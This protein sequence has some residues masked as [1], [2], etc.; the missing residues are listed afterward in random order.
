MVLPIKKLYEYLKKLHH[1]TIPE[2]YILILSLV[3]LFLESGSRSATCEINEKK[4][5][6]H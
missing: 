1:I 4:F 2:H 3:V 5:I 6:F